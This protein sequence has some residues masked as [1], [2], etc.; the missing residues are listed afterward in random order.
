MPQYSYNNIIILTNVIILE[1]LSPRFVYAGGLP[2]CYLFLTQV[3]TKM[4]KASI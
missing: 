4:I 1:L 2:P 3:K